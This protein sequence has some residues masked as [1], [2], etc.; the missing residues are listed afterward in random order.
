MHY[1]R[2]HSFLRIHVAG[3]HVDHVLI[4]DLPPFEQ[5][6]KYMH[7]RHLLEDKAQESHAGVVA[8]TLPPH[9]SPSMH[10]VVDSNFYL[11]VHQDRSDHPGEVS[12]YTTR[13]EQRLE[14]D[15][16]F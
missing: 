12:V 7:R 1:P 11:Y 9:P 2:L 13:L 6:P 8:A 15:N 10:L 14:L 3:L 16:C 4:V 5:E